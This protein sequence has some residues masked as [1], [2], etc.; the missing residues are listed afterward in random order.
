MIIKLPN[1]CFIFILNQALQEAIRATA[2]G[3]RKAAERGRGC[4]AWLKKV[5]ELAAKAGETRGGPGRA[6]DLSLERR[7]A[8]PFRVN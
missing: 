5:R 8:G 4:G 7:A 1:S 6:I 3:Q 2:N